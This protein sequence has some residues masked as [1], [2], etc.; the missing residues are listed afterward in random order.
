MCVWLGGDELM[1]I[2]STHRR[3]VP[4]FIV[5]VQGEEAEEHEWLQVV[6]G[7]HWVLE[8]CRRERRSN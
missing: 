1:M 2:H 7:I 6:Q 8:A 4:T 3:G 5:L